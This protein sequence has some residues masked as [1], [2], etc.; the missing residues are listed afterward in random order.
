MAVERHGFNFCGVP[1]ARSF[2]LAFCLTPW[3]WDVVSP[4]EQGLSLQMDEDT[5]GQRPGLGTFI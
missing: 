5:V 4:L 3:H 1:G 2:L